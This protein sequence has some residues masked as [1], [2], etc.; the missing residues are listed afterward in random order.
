M[1]VC[2]TARGCGVCTCGVVGA[3]GLGSNVQHA[4]QLL[5]SGQS[6]GVSH[7]CGVVGATGLGSVEAAVRVVGRH[8]RVIPP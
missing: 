6:I 1:M 3:G 5:K 2:V 7:T 8:P 4:V